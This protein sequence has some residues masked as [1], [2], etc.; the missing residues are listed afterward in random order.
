MKRATDHV[1][2]VYTKPE[3]FECQH[4]RGTEPVPLPM[5]V[6][7]LATRSE[8]FIKRHRACVKPSNQPELVVL[9][10]H[11]DFPIGECSLSHGH[12]GRHERTKLN[13]ERHAFD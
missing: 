1:V 13:G 5:D 4:C 7:E 10:G 12:Q 8:G 6:S 11:P 2:F 9:C 3:H